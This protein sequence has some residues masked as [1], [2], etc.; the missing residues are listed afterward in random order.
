MWNY[1]KNLFGFGEPVDPCNGSKVCQILAKATE[2][3]E[4]LPNYSV[5]GT[6]VAVAVVGAGYLASRRSGSKVGVT[7][8]STS[9]PSSPEASNVDVQVKATAT[10]ETV[11]VETT[12]ASDVK[13][14]LKDINK[15]QGKPAGLVATRAAQAQQE[16]ERANGPALTSSERIAANIAAAKGKAKAANRNV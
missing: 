10:V 2:A 15:G 4:S 12:K 6:G 13:E 9:T 14:A 7:V 8:D 11:V 1:I 5:V 3:Y 16:I